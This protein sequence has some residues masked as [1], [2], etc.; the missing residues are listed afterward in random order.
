MRACVR[1][2]VCLSAAAFEVLDLFQLTD[3]LLHPHPPDPCSP[4]SVCMHTH[5]M[6]REASQ[7]ER[8]GRGRSQQR[9]AGGGARRSRRGEK[10]AISFGKIV[11]SFYR[12]AAE[13]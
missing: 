4:A 6:H 12:Q 3:M 9:G 5:H 10:Q 7:R 11:C 1:V 8:G 13:L 2:R